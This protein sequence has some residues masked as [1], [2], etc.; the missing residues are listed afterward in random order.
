MIETLAEKNVPASR[1]QTIIEIQ[2]QDFSDQKCNLQDVVARLVRPFHPPP[3]IEI[4]HF[5]LREIVY[6]RIET[7]SVGRWRMDLMNAIDTIT[8]YSQIMMRKLFSLL[9]ECESLKESAGI[10]ELALWKAKLEDDDEHC[11]KMRMVN[12][13]CTI[14]GRRERCRINCGADIVLQ[15][16]LPFLSPN[17]EVVN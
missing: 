3:T 1:I 15:N 13:D 2:R 14:A 11:H 7:S 5:L 8:I 16:V 10:L 4:V 9:D 17:A 12:D 6:R